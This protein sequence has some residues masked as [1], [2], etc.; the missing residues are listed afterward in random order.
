[1]TAAQLTN[2]QRLLLGELAP[3][4]L[5][6]LADAPEYWCK[7]IR[8][9]QGGGTPV[10]PDWRAV[11]VWRQ[12]YSWGLA[13]T[14]LGDYMHERKRDDPAHKATLTWAEITRWVESLPAELRA[15]ARRFRKSDGPEQARVTEQLLAVPE[16][17]PTLW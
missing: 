10:N 17:E 5:L 6:A 15:D 7:H 12:T 4:Q 16:L 3:W 11:G 8:E 2:A 9:M 1:M 14:A 13:M